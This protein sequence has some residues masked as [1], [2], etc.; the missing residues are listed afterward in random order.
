MYVRIVYTQRVSVE[1]PQV[2]GS[3]LLLVLVCCCIVLC[4]H[5]SCEFIHVRVFCLKSLIQSVCGVEDNRLTVP[6]DLCDGVW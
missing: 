6:E 5:L 1:V 4:Y 2:T 3:L